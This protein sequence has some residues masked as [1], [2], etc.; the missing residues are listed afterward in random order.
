MEDIVPGL[1]DLD[2]REVGELKPV[3]DPMFV[4]YTGVISA[5]GRT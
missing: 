5:R 4:L 2:L 3:S 1:S